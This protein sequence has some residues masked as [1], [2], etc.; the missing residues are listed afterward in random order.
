LSD[1]DFQ[2]LLAFRT[3]LRRFLHW[4][5]QEAT[6]HGLTP[7]QH[8]LLLAVRGHGSA[9]SIREV[10]EHLLV[11]HNTAV[12]LVDRAQAAGLIRRATDR[13]DHRLSRLHLTAAGRRRLDSLA[14]AHL[15]ELARLQP[16]LAWLDRGPD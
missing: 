8:Q 13:G 15:E 9:P 14:A 4:S 2:R 10:A 11:K 3:A 1:E 6:D 5:E 16:A 7:A 12:E